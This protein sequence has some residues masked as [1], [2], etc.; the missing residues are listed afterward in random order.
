M[1]PQTL[2]R[3]KGPPVSLLRQLAQRLRRFG[4]TDG[5]LF[6]TDLITELANL[7]SQILIFS[8]RVGA[9]T[10]AL[11]YQF[12]SPRADRAG[13]DGDAI[14]AGKRTPVHVLR[15]DV[16]QSLPASNYVDAVSHF[17]IAR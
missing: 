15:G 14:H 1:L 10:T 5:R 17:G 3:A 2:Q 16:F 13:H 9:K 6:I 7:Q 11:F 4:P 8:Q 12:S